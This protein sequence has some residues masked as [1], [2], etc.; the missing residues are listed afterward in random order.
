MPTPTDRPSYKDKLSFAEFTAR[1]QKA[2]ARL[3]S[4][5]D[6]TLT[7]MAPVDHGD[8]CIH[9]SR[10]DATVEDRDTG[11]RFCDALCAEAYEDNRNEA[12]D[13]RNTERFYGG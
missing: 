4:E 6:V 8:W 5:F 2:T 3:R 1:E 9:C 13:Q 10:M 7:P 11:N 12:L